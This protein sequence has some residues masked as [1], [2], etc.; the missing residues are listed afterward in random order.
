MLRPPAQAQ[1]GADDLAVALGDKTFCVA[2]GL[3]PV[4]RAVRPAQ[5][6]GQCVGGGQVGRG[7]CTQGHAIGALGGSRCSHRVV[8]LLIS[9][10]IVV[11]NRLVVPV[12]I[13]VRL[14]SAACACTRV[15]IATTRWIDQLN[16]HKMPSP[17]LRLPARTPFD[18]S[19]IKET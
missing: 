2:E 14:T 10:V 4:G 13:R 5:V 1:P 9:A 8:L 15:Q 6:V 17:H 18:H 7:H 12:E 16:E 3:F 11:R 19:A